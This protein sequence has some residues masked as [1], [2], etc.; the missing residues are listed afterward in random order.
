MRS[1]P[2]QGVGAFNAINAHCNKDGHVEK[3]LGVEL[4]KEILG[5]AKITAM[6]KLPKSDGTVQTIAIYKVD[7]DAPDPSF[8]VMR[9]VEEDLTVGTPIGPEESLTGLVTFTGASTAVTGVSTKFLSELAVGDW[10]YA[11]T[12][13]GFA[14][15]VES[16]TDDTNLVLAT[17]YAGVGASTAGKRAA[18]H[19][20]GSQFDF[21]KLG[22]KIFVSNDSTTT[23]LY[24]FN[25]TTL[26][27]IANVTEKIYSIATDANRVAAVFLSRTD[28]SGDDIAASNDFKSGT[29][30]NRFG[31]YGSSLAFPKA[32]TEGGDGI[33][34]FAQ[35]GSEGHKVRGNAA[36]DD[37]AS[38]TKN[39]SYSHKGSGVT[40][41][42]QITSGS[43]FTYIGNTD[44]VYELNP[45]TGKTTELTDVGSVKELWKSLKK[46]FV[47]LGYDP[48]KEFLVVMAQKYGQNDTMLCFDLSQKKRPCWYSE[49][50]YNSC[51]ATIGG[52]LYGGS[53][54]DGKIQRLFTGTTDQGGSTQLFRYRMEK[55]GLG[56]VPFLKTFRKFVVY[57]EMHPRSKFTARVYLNDDTIPIFEK[58]F[59]TTNAVRGGSTIEVYGMYVFRLGSVLID[60]VNNNIRLNQKNARFNRISIE[61]E[62]KSSRPFKLKDIII[63]Y[64]SRGRFVRKFLSKDLS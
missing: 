39:P 8:Y 45:F 17:A 59:G 43:F 49:N 63:E 51:L 44:G 55:D 18:V 41:P 46:D 38:D 4:L 9:A 34:I 57:N 15:Q 62:E 2:D 12:E 5:V 37:V 27:K 23:P 30:I 29:G 14:A 26:T 35:V 13:S 6:Y 28:F 61:I 42:R 24:N 22:G 10:I 36:S 19:F 53:S 7:V 40:H 1:Q 31:T 11:S 32:V 64:K 60:A 3:T 48:S 20:T 25:S 47:A 16:I 50:Q 33:I 21:C 52:N 58:S 54:R 56:G